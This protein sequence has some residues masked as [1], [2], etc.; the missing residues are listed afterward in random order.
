MARGKAHSEELR[1]QVMAALLAGISASEVARRYSLPRSTVSRIRSELE[2]RL[3]QVGTE[4]RVDLDTLLLDALAAN[5]GAQ[6]RIVTTASEPDFIR[7][8]TAEGVAT[9]YEAFADKAIRL[10]EAASIGEGAG[11]DTEAEA[12]A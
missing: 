5:L 2:P 7:K 1:Q 10:L 4:S 6:K 8:Q 11:A 3:E 12:S 9:L